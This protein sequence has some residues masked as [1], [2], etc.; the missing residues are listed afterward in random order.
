[1]PSNT[2]RI[3]QFGSKAISSVFWGLLVGVALV[4]ILS[5]AGCG[6]DPKLSETFSLL[7]SP[8]IEVPL[9]YQGQVRGNWGGDEFD[10]LDGQFVHR[11]RLEGVIGPERGQ[12]LYG[13]TWRLMYDDLVGTG[14]TV[15]VSAHDECMREIGTIRSESLDFGRRLLENGMACVDESYEGGLKDEYQAVEAEAR[16]AKKG[17]WGVK[18]WVPSTKYRSQKERLYLEFLRR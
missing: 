13:A 9:T 18:D 11:V 16:K 10:V 8:I 1:M 7:P 2:T 12:S 14:V 4:V 17:I 6:E 5:I 15:E 3:L